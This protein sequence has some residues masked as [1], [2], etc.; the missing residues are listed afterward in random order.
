[1]NELFVLD[2]IV[3]VWPAPVPAMMR[4][5]APVKSRKSAD[6]FFD[7]SVMAVA[8]AVVA[9]PTSDT[10]SI[11]YLEVLFK[12]GLNALVTVNTVAV[13]ELIRRTCPIPAPSTMRTIALVKMFGI[14]FFDP[15][16]SVVALPLLRV[17]VSKFVRSY[18]R[19]SVTCPK[20]AS[21]PTPTPYG[22]MWTLPWR[23]TWNVGAVYCTFPA[24]GRSVSNNEGRIAYFEFTA[25]AGDHAGATVS[26]LPVFA[27]ISRI[28]PACAPL[29]INTRYP[30][31][32]LST[33]AGRVAP[34]AGARLPSIT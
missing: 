23:S 15:S 3:R 11:S 2:T 5:C 7:T 1:M 4:T 28:C 8:L 6:Q 20:A 18:R 22:R 34:T 13:L 19:I 27:V 26:T 16:V 31:H 29:V 32:W 30:I 10:I 33:Q 25:I 17:P 24:A 14:Q 21:S 12:L 9:I